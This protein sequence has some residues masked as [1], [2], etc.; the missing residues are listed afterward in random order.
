VGGIACWRICL[1]FGC[2]QSD[3]R[4]P[5]WKSTMCIWDRQVFGA[6]GMKVYLGVQE[7]VGPVYEYK[8]CIGTTM[9]AC[10]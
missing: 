9:Y 4:V 6:L 2:I 10:M 5:A 8:A 7:F 3:L 1:K